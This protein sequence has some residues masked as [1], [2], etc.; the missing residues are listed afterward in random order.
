MQFKSKKK[1]NHFILILKTFY[2]ESTY[3]LNFVYSPDNDMY[4]EY[5]DVNVY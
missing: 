2:A 5:I 1:C 3:F 4:V